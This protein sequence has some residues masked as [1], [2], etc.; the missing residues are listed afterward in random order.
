MIQI[1]FDLDNLDHCERLDDGFRD[2]GVLR[3]AFIEMSEAGVV[4]VRLGRNAECCVDRDIKH[5]GTSIR[6][7]ISS[8]AHGPSLKKLLQRADVV[9]LLEIIHVWHKYR[10]SI[11]RMDV[12]CDF[13]KI[14][15]KDVVMSHML[16]PDGIL[17]VYQFFEMWPV[18]KSLDEALNELIWKATRHL[19]LWD[20]T[21]EVVRNGLTICLLRYAHESLNGPM[22]F[23]YF[24]DHHAHALYDYKLI[25]K[26]GHDELVECRKKWESREQGIIV[27][28]KNGKD[29]SCFSGD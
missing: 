12:F 2:A 8:D 6:W 29:N 17:S 11:E 26:E 4:S 5:H 18:N 3:C 9:R 10:V 23:K 20:D 7:C 13:E 21:L 16:N 28:Q 14:L 22:S 24:G 25:T 1:V 27:V 15:S 19:D